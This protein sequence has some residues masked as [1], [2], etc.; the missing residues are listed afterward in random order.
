MRNGDLP[1]DSVPVGDQNVE[2]LLGTA[3]K[4]EDVDANFARDLTGKLCAAARTLAATRTP[5]DDERRRILRRRL[6]WAMGL[7]ASVAAVALFLYAAQRRA[8]VSALP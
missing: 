8:S 1:P 3:Y 7:A 6:G 5:T 2:R 4:P